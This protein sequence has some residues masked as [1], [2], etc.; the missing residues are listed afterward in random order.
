[1]FLGG[2][3]NVR[4]CVFLLPGADG[5]MV[6]NH[7]LQHGFLCATKYGFAPHVAHL[8][9]R[10]ATCL[11]QS[12]GL[13]LRAHMPCG[14]I[15]LSPAGKPGPLVLV[16]SAGGCGPFFSRFCVLDS[17]DPIGVC[18]GGSRCKMAPFCGQLCLLV[19]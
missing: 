5:T 9:R 11:A 14:Y 6:F 4:Q 12:R 18:L 15:L 17:W 13:A 10:A 7:V 8:F 3:K 16:H 19:L 1:M 2:E